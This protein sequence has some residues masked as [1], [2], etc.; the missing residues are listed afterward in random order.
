MCVRARKRG[1]RMGRG[2]FFTKAIL[3][4]PQE[5][6]AR[7]QREVVHPSYPRARQRRRYNGRIIVALTRTKGFLYVAH[8]IHGRTMKLMNFR[9]ILIRRSGKATIRKHFRNS[10]NSYRNDITIIT[11]YIKWHFVNLCIYY[12]LSSSGFFKAHSFSQYSQDT[13]MKINFILLVYGNVNYVDW[14]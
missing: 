7:S 14:H 13:N 10:K 1:F 8:W 5:Y 3:K 6:C 4:T 2:G 11:N 9:P 12:L